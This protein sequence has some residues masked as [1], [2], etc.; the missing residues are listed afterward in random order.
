MEVDLPAGAMSSTDMHSEIYVGPRVGSQSFNETMRRLNREPEPANSRTA[1]K[2]DRDGQQIITGFF[3]NNETVA[4][5]VRQT[6]SQ[7][8]GGVRKEVLGQRAPEQLTPV[9]RAQVFGEHHA[10]EIDFSQIEGMD[11]SA[12]E[13]EP[14]GEHIPPHELQGASS[15]SEPAATLGR[16]EPPTLSR[17]HIGPESAINVDLDAMRRSGA[18]LP[19]RSVTNNGPV[20]ETGADGNPIPVHTSIYKI[21]DDTAGV[22]RWTLHSGSDEPDVL[23]LKQYRRDQVSP[24]MQAQVFGAHPQQPVDLT[25]DSPVAASPLPVAGPSHLLHPAAAADP[26]RDTSGRWDHITH[27]SQRTDLE[28]I[29]EHGPLPGSETQKQYYAAHKLWNSRNQSAV[30]LSQQVGKRAYSESSSWWGAH[31]N[32][33]DRT[34]NVAATSCVY[35]GEHPKARLR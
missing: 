26:D 14:A 15:A 4:T 10:P 35:Y 28:P 27:V 12:F 33:H 21:S 8:T 5:V 20:M 3:K 9:L 25:E 19:D 32:A 17:D 24:R 22:Q 23:T 16:H 7:A 29:G 13:S 31:L 34:K 11:W 18:P 30:S 6:T 2:L 1:N